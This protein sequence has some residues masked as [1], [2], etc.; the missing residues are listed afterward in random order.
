[1][2]IITVI[3]NNNSCPFSHASMVQ[4]VVLCYVITFHPSL[5]GVLDPDPKS[6]G[7]LPAVSGRAGCLYSCRWPPVPVPL[8]LSQGAACCEEGCAPSSLLPYFCGAHSASLLSSGRDSASLPCSPHCSGPPRSVLCCS[9]GSPP[10]LCFFMELCLPVLLGSAVSGRAV[11]MC[12]Y[13]ALRRS[14]LGR[15]SHWAL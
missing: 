6:P 14:T 4:G 5:L 12:F 9:G 13:L 8:R 15:L 2:C 3:I 10:A 1:M 11:L 7:I